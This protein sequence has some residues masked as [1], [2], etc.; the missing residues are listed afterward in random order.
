M[1]E[2]REKRLRWL[3]LLVLG[4]MLLAA[5]GNGSDSRDTV[6]QVPVDT[7]PQAVIWTGSDFQ[8][9][10]LTMNKAILQGIIDAQKNGGVT[11]IDAAFICGDLTA[12]SSA[13][14]TREDSNA[15]AQAVLGLLAENWSL[16]EKSCTFL[17]GNHDV[18]GFDLAAQ[19]G[20][21]E[22]EGY[23]FYVLN[24]TDYPSAKS[25]TERA[26]NGAET[27]RLW[28]ME[29]ADE[30]YTRPIFIL[31]HVPLHQ[32]GRNDTRNAAY[33]V[34]ALNSGADRGL[35]IFYIFGH[36]HS[37]S[38][39]NFVGGS[40]IYLEPGTQIPVAIPEG[41]AREHF[42][43]REIRFTYFNAG[44]IGYAAS[45]EEGATTSSVIIFVYGDRVELHRYNGDGICN[46]K[47]PG[48]ENLKYDY[49][50]AD[51]EAVLLWEPY[52]EEKKSPAI[53]CLHRENK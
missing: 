6:P 12:V 42:E 44:Y 47:N 2:K 52:A 29:K 26:K 25:S 40:C 38:Y 35:Q 8:A 23:S 14:A 43:M 1:N 53:I 16:T 39:D 17:L 31:S 22:R 51:D 13:E 33:F 9:S 20:G 5:C 4:C 49:G 27:L 37:D 15:G 41:F 7:Q 3:W 19:T 24:E 10:S 50:G 45:N 36:N 34:D 21:C 32:S 30:G 11:E 18:E 28:L 46:M 48:E